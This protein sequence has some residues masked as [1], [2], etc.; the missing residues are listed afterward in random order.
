MKI[1]VLDCH[2]MREVTFSA[3]ELAA[4]AT[5]KDDAT[6]MDRVAKLTPLVRSAVQKSLKR[7][8]QDI[9]FMFDD[10]TQI[11]YAVTIVSL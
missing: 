6:P 5:F 10:N 4:M 1:R 9:N 11:D 3:D 7:H 2:T 8:A